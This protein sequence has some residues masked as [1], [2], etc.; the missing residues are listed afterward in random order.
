MERQLVT[1]K[2]LARILDR[3]GR[4]CP[5]KL[6]AGSRA[7]SP[8]RLA[9]ASDQQ[10]R[11]TLCF[12]TKREMK[13]AL[14]A[15]MGAAVVTLEQMALDR[16]LAAHREPEHAQARGVLAVAGWGAVLTAAHA[17]CG[18]LVGA[19]EATDVA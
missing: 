2:R 14:S 16:T 8:E 4:P 17:S 1:R 6:L 15:Q 10:K 7:I 9:I 18:H 5:R 19:E 12:V 13:P 3:H 11:I